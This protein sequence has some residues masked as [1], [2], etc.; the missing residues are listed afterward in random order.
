MEF[1]GRLSRYL[2]QATRVNTHQ[3]IAYHF[4]KFIQDEFEDAESGHA[5]DLFPYLE[6][7]L[8]KTDPKGTVAVKGRAD[9]LLGNL[10]IEFKTNFEEEFE[11]AK[12][13]LK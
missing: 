9:A 5:N 7:Y 1:E 10:I 6:Q 4:L 2:K 12:Y 3:S 8:K 13:Q 11:D